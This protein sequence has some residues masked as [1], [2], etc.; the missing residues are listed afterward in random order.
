[1]TRGGQPMDLEMRREGRGLAHPTIR[2]GRGGP[3]L[4]TIVEGYR[5]DGSG[6]FALVWSCHHE[7][8]RRGGE[9]GRDG[10]VI[11]DEEAQ[12]IAEVVRIT[13]HRMGPETG[14]GEEEG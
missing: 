14:A 3:V 1:M 9:F 8:R 7:A 4:A 10:T 5:R 6:G 2:L 11:F 13:G 12:C